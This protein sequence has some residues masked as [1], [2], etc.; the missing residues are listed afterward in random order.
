VLVGVDTPAVDGAALAVA[1]ADALRHVGRLTGLHARHGAG[2]LHGHW[3]GH[4]GAAR[5]A[6]LEGLADQLAPWAARHPDVPVE[7]EIVHG[8][9]TPALLSAAVRARL[10]VLGTRGETLLRG[11]SSGRPAVRCCAAARCP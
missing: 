10:V 2:L 8:Q 9:P 4:D 11:L 3:A 5:L 1:F 6:A 7:L